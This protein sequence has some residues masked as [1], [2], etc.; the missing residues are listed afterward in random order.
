[1]IIKNVSFTAKRRENLC[2]VGPNGSGK[3]TLLKSIGTLLEYKGR[4]TLNDT[5]INTFT[6]SDLAKKVAI[7]S[8]I[9]TIHFP[10]TIFETVALGRYCLLYTSRCV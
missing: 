10:Y 7:L 5:D 2:I 4:I 6:R 9:S 1:M 8:Q 3:S